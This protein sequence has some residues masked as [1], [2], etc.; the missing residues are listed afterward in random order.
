MTIR[1]DDDDERLALVNGPKRRERG[2]GDRGSVLRAFDSAKGGGM[3]C[4]NNYRE[5]F[6]TGQEL[7]IKVET[8]SAVVVVSQ[9]AGIAD[10]EIV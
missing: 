6:V 7:I 1:D 5:E 10:S 8:E 3:T 9:R 4:S 2:T